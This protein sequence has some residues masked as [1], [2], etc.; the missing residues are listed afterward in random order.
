MYVI[1]EIRKIKARK[2]SVLDLEAGGQDISV[3]S[4]SLRRDCDFFLLDVRKD[5]F[6][7]L[8]EC[9]E[10]LVIDVSYR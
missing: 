2:L 4:S 5:E 8:E 9:I 7:G 3:F 6:K 10:L 1:N